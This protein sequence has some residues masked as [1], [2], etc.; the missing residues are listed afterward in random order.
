MR[1]EEPL[2]LADAEPVL[3]DKKREVVMRQQIR[4]PFSVRR[5]LARRPLRIGI[6][7]PS[8]RPALSHKIKL[9]LKATQSANIQ[10]RL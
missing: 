10:L 3:F 9:L 6:L 7:L 1:T 8:R 5:L 2:H 4:E